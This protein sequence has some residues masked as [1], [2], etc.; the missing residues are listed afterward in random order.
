MK[1]KI[2]EALAE[3]KDSPFR[4]PLVLQG[5]RQVG[6]TCPVLK[7]A[8]GRFGNVVHLD[9]SA[10]PDA[11]RVFDGDIAP[12]ALLP[13]LEALGRLIRAS[14]AA[15]APP[16]LHDRALALH[17]D[18]LIAGGLPEAALAFSRDEGCARVRTVQAAV[19]GACLADATKYASPLGSSRILNVRRSVP[20]RLAK[21]N[22]RFQY[23]TIASSARS[24]VR[25][26]DAM[27]CG[28]WPCLVLLSGA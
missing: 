3:W 18:Y 2:E 19:A 14:H 11:C 20:E 4:K 17:R 10:Q 28:S 9:F 13:Q 21:E 22:H 24:S 26:A 12:D 8:R 15:D 6:K 27:A 25:S 16:G 1:R 7:F 23:A 5:A